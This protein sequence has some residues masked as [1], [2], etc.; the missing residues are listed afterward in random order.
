MHVVVQLEVCI[1]DSMR[2]CFWKAASPL[3]LTHISK[4]IYEE[5][6]GATGSLRDH[7]SRV[8]SA[9]WRAYLLTFKRLEVHCG[10]SVTVWCGE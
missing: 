7:S 5:V 1:V 3:H 9:L 6:S 4:A 8:K 10:A 2:L